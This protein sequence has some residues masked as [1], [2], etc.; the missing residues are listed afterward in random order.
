[1]LL[2]IRKIFWTDWHRASPKIEWANEDGSGRQIFLKENIRLPNSLA[3][4]WYSNEICW[5][6]AGT[7]SI[8]NILF[9][10]IYLS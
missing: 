10:K 5:S 1:M 7:F 2:K 9:Y 8:S 3:I 6:D 4:D